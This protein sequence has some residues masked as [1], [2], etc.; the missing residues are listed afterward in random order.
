MFDICNYYFPVLTNKNIKNLNNFLLE[1]EVEREGKVKQL[2]SVEE[3]FNEFNVGFQ[4]NENGIFHLFYKGTED[5]MLD[6]KICFDTISNFLTNRSHLY[7]S[8]D[9]KVHFSVRKKKLVR[10][11]GV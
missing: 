8:K 3:Y 9:K 10:I 6:Y 4:K 1:I 11:Y 7:F 5:V 2:N